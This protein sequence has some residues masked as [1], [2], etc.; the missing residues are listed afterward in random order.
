MC[1]D[2]GKLGL[3]E[4]SCNQTSNREISLLN[5]HAALIS[6][7]YTSPNRIPIWARAVSR[8]SAGSVECCGGCRVI[9][10]LWDFRR[11]RFFA[12]SA[13]RFR[14]NRN[15]YHTSLFGHANCVISTISKSLQTDTILLVESSDF[16]KTSVL[17]RLERAKGWFVELDSRRWP[18]VL[19]V[20]TKK[21][22]L[23]TAVV[24]QAGGDH[25]RTSYCCHGVVREDRQRS[26]KHL[27]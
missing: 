18:N 7:P 6:A 1:G 4:H 15:S 14:T 8:R 21:H 3:Q 10:E 27:G 25:T 23:F 11:L 20:A 17:W 5:L 26:L 22:K 9:D 16:S 13:K 19:T 24:A 2:K 12:L